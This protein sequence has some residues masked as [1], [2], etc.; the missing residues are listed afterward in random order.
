MRLIIFDR[1]LFEKI[2]INQN[3]EENLWK[4]SLQWQ[5]L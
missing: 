4:L 5:L 1:V 3:K 2:Y